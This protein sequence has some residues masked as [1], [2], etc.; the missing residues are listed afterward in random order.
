MFRSFI[1][2]SVPI[3]INFNCLNSE[4]S[5]R[6]NSEL[7]SNAYCSFRLFNFSTLY[8]KSKSL[9]DETL[10][11]SFFLNV[12]IIFFAF[13]KFTYIVFIYRRH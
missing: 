3:T 11:F 8:F 5:K 10:V 13:Y 2:Y 6:G 7:V 1:R 12:L 9:F 4:F